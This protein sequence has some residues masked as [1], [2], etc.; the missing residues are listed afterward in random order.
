M[1]DQKVLANKMLARGFVLKCFREGVLEDYHT[2]SR[3]IGQEEMKVMMREAV[4][5]AFTMLE[6][7]R[8]NDPRLVTLLRYSEQQTVKWDDPKLSS[9]LEQYPPA[10]DL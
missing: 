2:T 4:D 6:W 8:T 10:E 5:K 3:P 1:E 7:M 9:E